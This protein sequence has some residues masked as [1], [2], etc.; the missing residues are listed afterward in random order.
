MTQKR[1]KQLV[2]GG[3]VLAAL[4]LGSSAAAGAAT[5]GSRSTST[6]AAP[7]ASSYGGPPASPT[8]TRTPDAVAH[9]NTENTITRDVSSKARAVPLTR[10]QG[11]SA[12]AMH[13]VR[14][15]WIRDLYLTA[16]SNAP[17]TTRV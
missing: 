10:M 13:H 5:G 15:A 14:D 4:A 12:D 2:I 3:A 8:S 6:M 9:E 7:Q 1:L 16:M 17:E 11:S